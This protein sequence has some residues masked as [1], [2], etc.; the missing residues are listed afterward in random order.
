MIKSRKKVIQFFLNV[1]K[2]ELE[3]SQSLYKNKN[4]TQP[5]VIF[6]L[7]FFMS[8]KRRPKSDHF[9][10]QVFLNEKARNSIKLNYLQI[11][12]LNLSDNEFNTF[13]FYIFA[14]EKR[15]KRYRLDSD[16]FPRA[17]RG[18]R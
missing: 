14:G 16:H 7:E 11:I 10:S 12:T 1:H 9:L 3:I 13:H 17:A 15:R 2:L 18:T 8:V 5:W 4:F 6:F